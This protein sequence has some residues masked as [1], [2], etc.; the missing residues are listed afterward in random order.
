MAEVRELGKKCNYKNP[1]D[2]PV[3][4]KKKRLNLEKKS[5]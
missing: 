4:F 3:E 5:D 2:L 1:S